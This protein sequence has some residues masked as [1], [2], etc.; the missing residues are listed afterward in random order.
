MYN[1]KIPG[2]FLL[3][4]CLYLTAD[5]EGSRSKYVTCTVLTFTLQCCQYLSTLASHF[6]KHRQCPKIFVP[7]GGLVKG[8]WP[9]EAK[10]G[11]HG[12]CFRPTLLIL[13]YRS[14]RLLRWIKPIVFLKDRRSALGH[15]VSGATLFVC[16]WINSTTQ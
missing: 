13:P 15:R 16:S 11:E 3:Q 4:I 1:V 10:C 9:F 2:M 7:S 6:A 14:V 8:Q 12:L 5:R